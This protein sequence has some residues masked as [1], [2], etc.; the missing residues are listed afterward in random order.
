[1]YRLSMT[2]DLL[3]L[4]HAE[5]I[6]VCIGSNEAILNFDS[7]V[8]I[9]ILADFSVAAVAGTAVIYD[10][11]RQGAAAL[12][13]L[14]NDSIATAEATPRGDL[15]VVFASGAELVAFDSNLEFESFWIKGPNNEIIV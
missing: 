4:T 7:E 5:V 14:L 3:F 6:Q 9:T 1:M 2:E 15:R 13:G 10:D 12:V 11:P 8:R